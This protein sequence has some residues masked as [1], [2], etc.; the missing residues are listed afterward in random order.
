MAEVAADRPGRGPHRDRLQPHAREGAEIG[1]EH[2]PVARLGALA[3]EVEGIGVLHQELAAAHDAEARAHL[4]PELPLDVVEVARQV[5]VG[6]RVA[7]EDLGDHLLVGRA[8]EHVAV[9]PVLEAQ[10]LRP[11]G[12]VAPA[13]PPEV[14]GLDRRHQDLLRAGG[15]LLLADDLLH[16]LQHPPAERQPGIDAGRGLA[17]HAG[18][19]HQPVRGDLRV[20]RRFLEGG[21]EGSGQAQRGLLGNTPARKRR[22]T[23]GAGAPPRQGSRVGRCEPERFESHGPNCVEHD[24]GNGEKF[25][26]SGKKLLGGCGQWQLH[27]KWAAPLGVRPEFR[28]E[29]PVTRQE[30]K[31][32]SCR[33]VAHTDIAAQ[34]R[35]M[36]RSVEK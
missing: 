17:D 16:P 12:V 18:A 27:K 14:G 7:A 21:Q 31:P 20:R 25:R 6:A 15:V 3:V 32:S 13:L 36:P 22:R 26:H 30:E 8:V 23:I 33:M 9:V 11:V 5:A 29:T 28:E 2:P 24:A 10:H 4:V 1:H 35:T 19:Q 34:P